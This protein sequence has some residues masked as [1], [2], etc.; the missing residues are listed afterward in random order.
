MIRTVRIS[1]GVCDTPT[2]LRK[3]LESHGTLHV[4]ATLPPSISSAS[5]LFAA[6]HRL[7]CLPSSNKRSVA[8]QRGGCRGYIPVGGESGS[9]DYS[10]LP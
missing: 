10:E 8:M 7:F 2:I 6:A 5:T 9:A 4:T 1:A 3:A